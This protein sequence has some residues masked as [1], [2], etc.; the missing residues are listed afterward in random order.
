VTS[1]LLEPEERV[2]GYLGRLASSYTLFAFLHETPDVQSVVT[3]MFS[4]GDIALD[5]SVILPLLA[6]TLE[7]EPHRH[8]TSLINAAREA[9]IEVWTTPGTIE[10]VERHLNRVAVCARTRATDWRGDYPYLYGRYLESGRALARIGTWIETFVGSRRRE[11]DLQIYLSDVHGIKTRNLTG[12]ETTDPELW[13]CALAEWQRV[14]DARGA[15]RPDRDAM[16]TL[17]LARH[18]TE[19]YVWILGLR[20]AKAASPL[21]YTSWWLTLDRGAWNVHVSVAG[22]LR[23]RDMASPIM[24]P[25]FLRNYLTFG[26]LR[27]LLPRTLETTLPVVAD[28]LL[29]Q[30][31]PPELVAIA[32][33][34]RVANQDLPERVIRRRVRDA[35]DAARMRPGRIAQGG[36]D[37]LKERLS[38]LD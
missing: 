34:V 27:R 20:R 10:E 33:E 21:G 36:L 4:G 19:S 28:V 8:F 5:S 12:V 37:G 16:M 30:Y 15:S 32:D 35:L 29:S 24:S 3:K 1:L 26:P 18:D 2:H 13:A 25:D 23:R 9:G 22:Q 17:R 6:D 38:G 31:V 7:E 11:E 14:H